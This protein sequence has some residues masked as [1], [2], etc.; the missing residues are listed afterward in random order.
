MQELT[1]DTG[2]W[3]AFWEKWRDTV[4]AIPG[5]KEALLERTGRELREEVRR[6]VD[7]SGL[8]DHRY[9]RIKQWQGPHM[10]SG[11]GYV[12]VRPESVMVQSGGGNKTPL[13]AGAL[14][15][16]LTSGHKV[17]G[18]SGRW[19]R[20]VSRAEKSRVKGFGF[21]KSA[22]DRAEQIAIQAAEEFLN[23]LAVELT[24]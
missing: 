24:L 11:R 16:Y 8:D 23:S 14:T 1:M 15:N 13:N 7:A 2:G 3:S 10:G 19:K 12:A 9:G 21:Y 18:P 4:N 20:Y 6:A 5:M 17:R 22:G